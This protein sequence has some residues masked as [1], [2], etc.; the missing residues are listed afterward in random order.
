MGPILNILAL[1]WVSRGISAPRSALVDQ[2]RYDAFVGDEF[3]M[4]AVKVACPYE[5]LDLDM[6][7]PRVVVVTGILSIDETLRFSGSVCALSIANVEALVVSSTVHEITLLQ[8]YAKLVFNA[9]VYQLTEEGQL[10]L[11]RVSREAHIADVCL[12]LGV[13]GDRVLNN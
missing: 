6:V 5:T 2:V 3:D 11:L 9:H 13:P 8:L 7:E 10:I 12:H 1:P 4:A